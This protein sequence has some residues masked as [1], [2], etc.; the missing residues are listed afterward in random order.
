[1]T[2]A[3]VA[4][5]TA[6]Y[7]VMVVDDSAVIRGLLT[8]ALEADPEIAVLVS[9]SNGEMAISSLQRHDIE[10]VI[11]DIEMPVMSSSAPFQVP[12]QFQPM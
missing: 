6:P 11:L 3:P 9:A 1:M 12:H 5:A 8:R 7:R 2:G 4:R 10:I